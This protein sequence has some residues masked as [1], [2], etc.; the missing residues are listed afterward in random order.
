MPGVDA[1]EVYVKLLVCMSAEEAVQ[2]LHNPH[3]LLDNRAPQSLID[4][5]RKQDVLALLSRND[6]LRG[7]IGLAGGY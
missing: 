4:E 7:T 6:G 2:W 3:P 1:C 5:G